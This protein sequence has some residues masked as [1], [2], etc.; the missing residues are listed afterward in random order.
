MLSRNITNCPV[1][2]PDVNNANK[3]FG[4]ILGGTRGKTVRQ[5]TEHVATDYV[6]IPRDFWEWYRFVSLVADVMFVN[7]ITFLITMSRGIKLVTVEYLSFRTPKELS[8]NLKIVTKLYGRGSMIVQ[9]ISMDMEFDS[10]TDELMGKTVVNTSAANEHV[11]EIEPCICTV[12]ERCCA[13]A[14]DLPFNLLHKTIVINMIYICIIWL[15]AFSVKN[16]VS[17]EFSPPINHGKN[18]AEL[19][20]ALPH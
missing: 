14:S 4:P 11:V 3:I 15:N 10:T 7:N 19:V 9:T 2:I 5:N 12:K 16:G 20:K 17:Q 6:A 13:V 18:Q 8:K 1:T